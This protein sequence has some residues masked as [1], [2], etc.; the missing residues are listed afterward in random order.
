MALDWWN[1]QRS[2]YVDDRLSGMMLGMTIQTT[3]AQQ[4]RALMEATAYGSRLILDTF[5]AGGVPVRQIVAC[6]GIPHKNPLMMQIYADVLERPIQTVR[7]TETTALGA[8][9]MAAAAAGIYETPAEAVHCMTGG[10]GKVYMPDPQRAAIYRELYQEYRRLAVYFAEENP[11]MHCLRTLSTAA[12][13]SRC[14]G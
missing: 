7:E 9:V 10:R 2:P 12:D 8:A 11:V 1:G 13:T 3:P 5:E 4:Y 14:A 6:G